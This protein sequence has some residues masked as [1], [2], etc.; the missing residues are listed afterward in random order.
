MRVLASAG[1]FWLAVLIGT[2]L[3]A[4]N[5]E[6][7]APPTISGQ[8]LGEVVA[9]ETYDFSPSAADSD[10]DLLTFTVEN[11]PGWASFNTTTG[12]LIGTPVAGHVGDYTDILIRVS[13]GTQSSSLPAFDI[14]VLQSG[15]GSATLSWVPPT[16]RSDGSALLNLAGYNIFY[17]RS[18]GSYSNEIALN[19]AGLTAHV[20][21]NLAAGTWFFAVT[22]FDGNGMESSHSAE[23]SKTIP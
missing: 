21:E 9:G 23:V 13:D 6:S 10:G 15:N 7:N 3:S 2:V 22:A 12:Q 16:T 14:R 11:K 20:I 17:G 8:P 4:C 1:R 5:E 19:N 18:S